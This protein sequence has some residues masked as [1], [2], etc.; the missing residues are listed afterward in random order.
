[1]STFKH[2]SFDYPATT[3]D[4]FGCV[5]DWSG[6]TGVFACEYCNQTFGTWFSYLDTRQAAAQHR[7]DEHGRKAYRIVWCVVCGENRSEA[8]GHCVGCRS[9]AISAYAVKLRAETY[10]WAHGLEEADYDAA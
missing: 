9:R 7:R 1:M 8:R 5:L 4:G 6:I 3:P 2:P 10:A